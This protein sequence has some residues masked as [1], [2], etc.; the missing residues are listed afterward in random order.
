MGNVMGLWKEQG[1]EADTSIVILREGRAGVSKDYIE[2]T[3]HSQDYQMGK[4][5]STD[6]KV[7][8]AVKID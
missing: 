8:S 4:S 1:V 5:L 6:L 7:K 2:V 3:L